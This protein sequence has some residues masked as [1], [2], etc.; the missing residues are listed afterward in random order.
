MISDAE[1]S[2]LPVDPELAFVQ[3]EKILRERVQEMETQE[4][5]SRGFDADSYRLEYM[6][7]VHAAAKVFGIEALANLAV[8]KADRNSSIAEQYRQFVTGVDYVTIQ[9][10]LH[11]ARS[12][13]QGSVGLDDTTRAKIHHFIKQI[14]EAIGQSELPDD[15]R[16][17]LYD[18]LNKFAAEVDKA[19]TA[20]QAGMAVYIAV[21]DAIGQGFQKLEPARKWIDSIGALLGRAKEG[22][23]RADHRLPSP[24]ERKRLE[25]PPEKQLPKPPP[26]EIVDDDI[27]F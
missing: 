6:N 3:F 18:K 22:E 2:E 8:P 19:R 11:S 23:D 9:I 14:R 21:C 20:L 7:K 1:M 17:A 16:D 15:K 4:A 13:R 10:R 12:N 24:P 27:P 25:P 5:D 26:P